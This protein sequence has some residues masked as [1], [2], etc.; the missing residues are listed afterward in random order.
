MPTRVLSAAKAIACRRWCHALAV[1]CRREAAGATIRRPPRQR[2]SNACIDGRPPSTPRTSPPSAAYLL[3]TLAIRSKIFRTAAKSALRDIAAALSKPEIDLHYDEPNIHDI[4]VSGDLAVV[5]LTCTLTAEKNGARDVTTEEGK[6]FSPRAGRRMVDR[7][8]HRLLNP[9]LSAGAQPYRAR[10]R[11]P[12][13]PLRT[14]ASALAGAPSPPRPR[15]SSRP[16]NPRR[17]A[18]PAT[19]LRR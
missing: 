8:L 6:E 3:P 1:Q 11:Q 18:R 13:P 4:L 14:R 2:S 17:H 5:R 16:E 7:A 19:R 9:A 12:S 15:P 10:S